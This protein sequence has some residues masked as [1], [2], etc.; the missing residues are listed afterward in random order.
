MSDDLYQRLAR[1]LDGLPGG[2][3]ATGSGVELRILRRLF[4]PEEA[5]LAL[6]LTLLTEPARV[7]AHRAGLETEEAATRLYELSKK[8]LI[9]R[10]YKGGEPLYM[11]LQYVIGIWEFH[12]NDLD[13]GLIRDM[14]E[15]LPQ[16]MDAQLWR[17]AP[18]LRTIPIRAD[19][20]VGH[21]ILPHEEAETLVRSRKRFA[22]AP[23]ICRKEHQ[24]V[25]A[26]CDRPM[27]SCLVFNKAADYYIENGLAREIDL[28]ETLRILRRADQAGLVLQP[29]NYQN[30]SNICCCCGD[31]CQVLLAFKRHPEP[32]SMVSTP[33]RV[34]FEEEHCSGCGTCLE[35]CQMEAITEA[36]DVVAVDLKR[37]I[38]CGLCVTTCPEECLTLVRKPDSEQPVV[39]VSQ[40]KAYLNLARERGKLGTGEIAL[41]ALRSAKDRLISH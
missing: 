6:H 31:C 34:A 21:E 26:G 22:V 9:Y 16:L 17:K 37:C 33:F 5:E 4:T 40:V 35:R 2:F 8:G 7:I 11:A 14:N 18:Q 13:P 30:I 15:Y 23:C 29:G 25:G 38:G 32:A 3:P 24:M 19:I 10:V 36:G 39:P 28:E 20:P 41:M 1:H 12:V 27:E